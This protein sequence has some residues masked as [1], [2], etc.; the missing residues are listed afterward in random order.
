MAFLN[1]ALPFTFMGFQLSA[2]SSSPSKSPALKN[3]LNYYRLS[4]N[5]IL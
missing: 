2:F 1:K 4:C 3:Y 5:L